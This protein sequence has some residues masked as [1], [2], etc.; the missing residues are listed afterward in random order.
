[1]SSDSGNLERL[2]KAQE[3]MKRKSIVDI[4]YVRELLATDIKLRTQVEQ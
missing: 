1:M 2:N 3:L 4:K